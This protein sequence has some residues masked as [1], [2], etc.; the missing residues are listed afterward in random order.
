M[1]II[2]LLTMAPVIILAIIIYSQD[3]YE[4]ESKRLLKKLFIFGIL[5]AVAT[6]V[7]SIFAEKFFL[8]FQANEQSLDKKNLFTYIFVTIAL[9]EEFFKF[10]FTMIGS[11]NDPE[12]G[13]SFDGIVYA[14]YVALGF[15]AIE[16]FLY[17]LT[18]ITTMGAITR[19][20]IR[21]VTAVPIHAICGVFMGALIGKAKQLGNKERYLAMSFS[22]VLA[23]LIPAIIHAI[24]NWTIMANYSYLH[25]F[26]V[27]IVIYIIGIILVIASAKRSKDLLT[28]EL[29]SAQAEADL[30]EL[31][32][33]P[34]SEYIEA[35][36]PNIASN[37]SENIKENLDN[38]AQ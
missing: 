24:Y 1:N 12:F 26:A 9:V 14:V 31:E 37:Y 7:F 30:R 4:K 5:S 34:L 38:K 15:A 36:S 20:V 33:K 19:A 22:L 21:A 13:H 11:W 29:S 18:A 27:V 28:D 23:V 10:A 17:V 16:N 35:T 32:A 25:F 3:P 2:L 8:I 6:V